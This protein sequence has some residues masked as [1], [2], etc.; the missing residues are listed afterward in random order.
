MGEASDMELIYTLIGYPDETEWLEFKE[1]NNDPGR[2]GKDISA[3]ANIAAS[4]GRPRAYKI[5]GVEDRG[6]ALV[7]TS[8]D[9][10]HTKAKGNQD[11]Q[12]WLRTMLSLHASY[13]FN[14]I[15]HE[16]KKYVA[17]VID[18]ALNRPVCFDKKAYIR[19]GSSTTELIPGSAAE[20]KLWS[21]LQ[22]EDYESRPAERDC[23]LL[24]IEEKIDIDAYFSLLGMRRPSEL[25][26]AVDFLK[27]QGLVS[28]QDNGR[29]TINNLGALLVGRRLTAF[30][31]L[32]KRQI[33][34]VSYYGSDFLDKASDTT[35]DCGYAMALSQAEDHISSLLPKKDK[36]S[37]AFRRL[38]TSYPQRAI[39]ELL[40]N[41]VIHQ[42]LADTHSAPVVSV[43][44]GRIEFSNPGMSLVPWERMLNAQ[45]KSRNAALA[46]LLRQM[47]LCEEQGSG[48]DIVVAS[49]ERE[50]LAA[51]KVESDETL[52][53][54]VTLYEDNAYSRM[55]KAERMDAVYWHAC[56]LYAGGNSMGNQSL[57]ERFG[58]DDSR[59]NMVAISRLIKE[60]CDEGI[61]KEEDEGSGDKY[62]RY[63]PFWA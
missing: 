44:Q 39:R 17:L 63:I 20:L 7:G 43:F 14:V 48:W 33:R 59:K 51:P 11:L 50:H 47:H 6:H 30:P 61:I 36:L 12:I 37:G 34:V 42:D 41:M 15:E 18:A 53:T 21:R 52:G 55:K 4:L 46:D 22:S 54:R 28:A 27:E 58:L 31:G 29:Y 1:G 19:V 38:E 16:G 56:L 32:R 8:F 2:I 13:E 23:D 60:C 24:E 10:Y 35:F 26:V 9:P 57:R 45:P 5:W 49:C 25:E 40:S 3:L 62:R